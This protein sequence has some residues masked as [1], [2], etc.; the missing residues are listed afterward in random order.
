V[1]YQ[2]PSPPTSGWS[3]TFSV[4]LYLENVGAAAF[5]RM[6][7]D[8]SLLPSAGTMTGRINF[9]VTPEGMMNCEIDLQL[10][11]IQYAANPRSNYVRARRTEVERGIK[12]LQ[13]S[14]HIAKKMQRAMERSRNT[15][16]QSGASRDYRRGRA[17]CVSRRPS[18]RWLRPSAF[19][20]DGQSRHRPLHVRHDRKDRRSAGGK[21][22]AA[23][24]RALMADESGNGN[25]MTRGL[26]NVGRGVRRLFGGGGDDKKRKD[27]K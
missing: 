13:V 26:R 9:V 18:G 14:D 17:G 4:S 5:A 24:A 12:E 10:R 23:V 27:P 19:R 11:N 3:P 8:A 21:R 2:V 1:I 7:T 20:P 25:P 16:G 22:G 6:V 15:P